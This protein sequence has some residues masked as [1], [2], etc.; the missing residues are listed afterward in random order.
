MKE[1]TTYQAIL[2]EGEAIGEA[3]GEAKGKLAEAKK[4]LRMRGE[5]RFGPP[6]ARMT[7]AL[8]RIADLQRLEA[9]AVKLLRANSWP[10][11]LDLPASRPARTLSITS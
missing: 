4:W 11:L 8:E 7:K 3:R 2:E 10:E 1:S 6:D 9:L 5:S